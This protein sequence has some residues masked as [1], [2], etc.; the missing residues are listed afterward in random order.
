M[1]IKSKDKMKSDKYQSLDIFSNTKKPSTPYQPLPHKTGNSSSGTSTP[2]TPGVKPP[3]KEFEKKLDEAIKK[4][5]ERREEEKKKKQKEDEKIRSSFK[6]PNKIEERRGSGSDKERSS[7]DKI[8][9]R[10]SSKSHESSSSR[11]KHR[12]DSDKDKYRRSSSDKER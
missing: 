8:K 7:S 6:T 12:H 1:G 9:D 2:I 4:E 10:R 5:L 11:D 3:K